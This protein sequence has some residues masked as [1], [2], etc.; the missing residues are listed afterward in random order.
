MFKVISAGSFL[1][2]CENGS[3]ACVNRRWNTMRSMVRQAGLGEMVIGGGL[4]SVLERVTSPV[5]QGYAYNWTGDY[6]GG[7]WEGVVTNDT[8]VHPW[9]EMSQWT[10]Q[11]RLEHAQDP[12]PYVP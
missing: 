2:H 3:A 7:P 11:H 1:T 4:G 12:I 10:H 5:Y 9:S 8:S 6:A